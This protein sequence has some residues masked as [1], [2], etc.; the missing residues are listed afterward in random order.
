M[1][2]TKKIDKNKTLIAGIGAALIDILSHETDEFLEKLGNKKG[3]MTYV[4]VEFIERTLL[5]LTGN[6]SIVPGGAACNTI[7]GIGQLGGETRFV[8]KRGM[9]NFG[10]LFEAELKK[11]N[12]EPHLFTT[13]TS[14]GRVLSIITPDAQRSMF[15][16]LGASS[17]MHPEEISYRCFQN[18]A[19]V[20][21]E[22][23]LVFNP[24][25]TIAALNAA[26]AAGSVVAMD[27]ASFDVVESSKD[28]LKKIIIDYVDILI[29]NEDESK[30]FTGY[31]DE[32]EALKALAENVDVAVLKVGKRG[33]FISHEGNIIKVEPK[34]TGAAVD[35]TGAG[36]LWASGFLFGLINGYPLEKCGELASACGYEI[37]QVVGAKIPEEGWERIKKILE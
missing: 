29:A 37:C 36:D 35:T 25:L 9:G 32:A 1:D 21:L 12:V 2:I 6:A 17:E 31:S 34:G 22:G 28:F 23:Y 26:K 16:L 5:K 8:G 24:D 13:P 15:T 19:I 3:G 7:I 18:A 14:T 30:V 11:S 20:F 33:S 4:D 27:L 10:D